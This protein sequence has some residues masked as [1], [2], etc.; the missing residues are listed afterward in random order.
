MN[1]NG[2]VYNAMGR[3]NRLSVLCIDAYGVAVK[4]GYK[5]TVE[6]WLESLKGE[7][8][9]KGDKGDKGE[10]GQPPTDEQVYQAIAEYF[11][12]NG[13]SSGKIGTVDLLA[14]NWIADGEGAYHQE[15]T[16]KGLPEAFDFTDC[17]IDLTPSREI[18]EVLYHKEAMMVAEND[19]GV[20]TVYLYGQKLTNDYEVQVTVTEVD[21]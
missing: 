14:D 13:I 9:D 10:Q 19:D 11:E 15:V 21:V 7:K 16:V 3:I 17:Q 18:L 2:T 8:G 4:N 12:R 20:V 6:E 5:G 1:P